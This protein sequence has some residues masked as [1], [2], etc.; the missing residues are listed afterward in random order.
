MPPILLRA[1][2]G[3]VLEAET[4]SCCYLKLKLLRFK[5]ET[6]FVLFTAYAEADAEFLFARV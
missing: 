6:G 1:L 4:S 2:F 5:V 3:V